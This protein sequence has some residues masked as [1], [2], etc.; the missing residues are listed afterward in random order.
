MIDF[1]KLAKSKSGGMPAKLVELFDQLDRKASHGSLRLV[2]IDALNALDTQIDKGDVV[3]KL[4]T[5]SG[6]TVVGLVYAE[7]MRRKYPG[8][9]VLYL[10][11][12]NQLVDQ[13]I[14]AGSLIGVQ[15]DGFPKEGFPTHAI[16]GKT[17]LACTYDRLF[18][19]RNVFTRYNHVPS[20]IILDDVHSGVDRVRNAYTAIVPPKAYVKI[21]DIFGPLCDATDPAIWRGIANNESDARYEVPYWI[22][23]PQ[24]G[25]VGAILEPLKN[26]LELL[27]RWG[28]IARY[29]EHARLCISGTTAELSLPVAASEENHAYAGAKRRL[30]MSASIKDGT[31]LIRDLACS[32]EALKR[33]IEPP[34]DRGAG[35]R[36]ILPVAL[37]DPTLKKGKIA[38]LCA[39]FSRRAQV[40]VLTS[41]GKQAASWVTAGA[42]AKQGQEVDDAVAQLKLSS[43]GMYVVFPQRFDGVD[44]P[45]DACRILVIDGTPIGE[46]LCDQI[47]ADRQRNSPG[48]N[49][50]VVNRFEQ[51]L[52]R[53]VRSS[54]DYAA[55]LLVGN[56]IAAFVGRRD[57]KA[58]LESHTREQ[59][60]LGKDLADQMRGDSGDGLKAITNAVEALLD[61]NEQW[62]EVHRERLA[63]VPRETRAGADLTQAE[64]AAIAERE[65]WLQA[66]A[67]NNQGAVGR[68]QAILDA[69]GLHQIQR[70]ELMFRMAAFMHQFDAG[71][72]ATLYRGA[73][74]INSLLPRPMQ[75]PDRRYSRVREQAANLRD[76]LGAFT[77]Q[78]A[79]VSRLEEI[80]AKLAF[81]SDADLVEEGMLELGEMLGAT[82]SRPEKETGRGPDVLW[83]FDDVALCIEAKNE[84][85][86]PISKGDAEQLLL[87]IEWCAAQTDVRREDVVPVFVTNC[88]EAD[89][90]EDVS[91]GPRFL[92]ERI[93]FGIADSL[94]DLVNG[95]AYEGP[96]FNDGAQMH[97]KL[98]DARLS[99]KEIVARLQTLK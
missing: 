11:P 60:D 97:R 16:E 87:S 36:M 55:I 21:R 39:R 99:G 81:S 95:I 43:K 59:I 62:K 45:D 27:F 53:A 89:R 4:S 44:L 32:D 90:R 46:R 92:S 26:E 84:K 56:D 3:L 93:L 9:M 68:L 77:T 10:A 40:V 25:A 74:Q 75:L 35:E 18:N 94:R 34:S 73:F 67:R 47:D 8:E 57:V 80:R 30:F 7:Y 22:W 76:Y 72:A 88:V 54:A 91:Y 64:R 33:I 5:G 63:A 1:S 79:A 48:Y 31:G 20:T 61:R 6:K 50:R 28:N 13:V 52:G 29:L 38:E 66:K 14:E 86:R 37:I 24:S 83:I 19:S 98:V 96:L 51:A 70:A 82:S 65:A 17:V 71:R 23:L 78:N 41:S 58:M 2:Q 69:G 12:T 85:H 42:V 15:V 49:V